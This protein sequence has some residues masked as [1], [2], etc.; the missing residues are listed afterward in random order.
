MLLDNDRLVINTQ[1]TGLYLVDLR[2]GARRTLES[3]V[4]VGGIWRLDDDRIAYVDRRSKTLVERS[5]RADTTTV[6]ARDALSALRVGERS[7]AH[8]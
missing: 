2:T 4:E 1:P 5:L 8:V 7:R 3:E 6:I